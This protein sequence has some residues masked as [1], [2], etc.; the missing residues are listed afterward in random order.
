LSRRFAAELAVR[1][2]LELLVEE[3][4]QTIQALIAARLGEAEER[5]G[6]GGC[7]NDA[8]PMNHQ[9]GVHHIGGLPNAVSRM[10]CALFAPGAP[11]SR[12]YEVEGNPMLPQTS[13]AQTSFR[14]RS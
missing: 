13:A 8:H 2:A 6:T 14:R 12:R 11:L 4:D 10:R 5:R 3:R 7:R 1:D 9:A